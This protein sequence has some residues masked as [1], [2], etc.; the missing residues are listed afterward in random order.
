MAEVESTQSNGK[1]QLEDNGD[2]PVKSKMLKTEN[3]SKANGSNNGVV[4]EAAEKVQQTG[5]QGVVQ[6]EESSNDVVA[7][8]QSDAS[9]HNEESNTN[10]T[11]GDVVTSG[12]Q[13]L[14]TSRKGKGAAT[15]TQENS[16]SAYEDDEDDEGDDVDEE[17][18][19]EEESDEDDDDDEGE[20]GPDDEDD[21][22]GEEDDDEG[23]EGDDDEDDDDEDGDE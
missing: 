22:G 17:D 6:A 11:N 1:H 20:D 10:D 18:E 5:V 16:T 9:K 2:A 15:A 14:R 3:G 7:N 21:D 4:N 12:S 13:L 8:T 23:P 19:G